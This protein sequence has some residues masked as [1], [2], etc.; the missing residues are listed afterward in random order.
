MLE[1]VGADQLFSAMI[2][3][4]NSL[5]QVADQA[6]SNGIDLF[7]EKDFRGA[8]REFRRAVG[9][10]QFSANGPVAYRYLAMAYDRQEMPDKA[11]KTFK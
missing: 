10:S 1:P 5:G 3:D 7:Q 9:M 8:E 4:T 11:L 2:A 6:L